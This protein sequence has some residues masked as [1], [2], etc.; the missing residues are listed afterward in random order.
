MSSTTPPAVETMLSTSSAAPAFV[1]GAA[2]ALHIGHYALPDNQ[3][4]TPL[5][6]R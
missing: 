3:F 6:S 5:S 4:G 2:S 1:I